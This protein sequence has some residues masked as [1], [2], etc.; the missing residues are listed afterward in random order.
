M[1][2]GRGRAGSARSARRCRPV[3]RVGGVPVAAATHPIQGAVVGTTGIGYIHVVAGSTCSGVGRYWAGGYVQVVYHH[4]VVPNLRRPERDAG[5]RS[6][7]VRFHIY[8]RAAHGRDRHAARKCGCLSGTEFP[9][10]A[11]AAAAVEG[12][13]GKGGRAAVLQRKGAGMV[14]GHQTAKRIV[15]RALENRPRILPQR[16]WTG[17]A[18][19]GGIVELHIHTRTIVGVD[20]HKS[21]AE[22]GNIAE[23]QFRIGSGGKVCREC[24]VK[25]SHTIE[26]DISGGSDSIQ[27][28]CSVELAV[29]VENGRCATT[30]GS[31]GSAV[32]LGASPVDIKEAVG[33]TTRQ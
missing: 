25:R 17:C 32:S 27:A 31:N 2:V 28:Y 9:S 3:G 33:D 22:S 8:R 20:G 4:L 18:E 13:V 23:N 24:A 12:G 14:Y 29:P 1:V 6:T 11:A 5:L 30:Y 15:A 7:G 16:Q 26:F 21:P 19:S 10:H